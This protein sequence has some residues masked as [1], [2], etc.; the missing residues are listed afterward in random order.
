[1]FKKKNAGGGDVCPECGMPMTGGSCPECGEASE[2]TETTP[3]SE[4]EGFAKDL[5]GKKKGGKGASVPKGAEPGPGEQG[6]APISKVKKPAPF[7][8]GAKA[9][10]TTP[11][12]H[13]DDSKA[14]GRGEKSK[15]RGIASDVFAELGSKKKAK[16]GFGKG[17]KKGKAMR[18]VPQQEK[19]GI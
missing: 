13:K 15:T 18:F 6:V 17:K 9:K 5:F 8:K 16:T 3:D 12:D 11:H 14:T 19:M 7:K 4:P 2:Y 1:M 10:K